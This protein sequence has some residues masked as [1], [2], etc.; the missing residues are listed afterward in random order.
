MSFPQESLFYSSFSWDPFSSA[1]ADTCHKTD[2]TLLFF[3]THLPLSLQL[4]W[5]LTF[6][7]TAITPAI[8]RVILITCLST[9]ESAWVLASYEVLHHISIKEVMF[10]G[11]CQWEKYWAKDRGVCEWLKFKNCFSKKISFFNHFSPWGKRN[12]HFAVC[13]ALQSRST[14]YMY[15]WY[16]TTDRSEFVQRWT[17]AGKGWTETLALYSWHWQREEFTLHYANALQ[18]CASC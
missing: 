18:V 10:T 11:K 1:F 13:F 14:V 8:F 5:F 15:F 4:S 17:G 9:C 6:L 12:P 16:A 2:F 7:L 3:L